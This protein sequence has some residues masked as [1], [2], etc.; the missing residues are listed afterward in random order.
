[1]TRI[2]TSDSKPPLDPLSAAIRAVVA[3][4][5]DRLRDELIEVFEA[6][7]GKKLLDGQGLGQLL[8]VTPATIRKLRSEGLPYVTLGAVHRYDADAVLTWLSARQNVKG[9]AE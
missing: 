2:P 1:M 5:I 3:T 8:Q 4:E 7:P 9:G 6:R